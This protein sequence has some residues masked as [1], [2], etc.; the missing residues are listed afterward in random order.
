[1]NTASPKSTAS[2]ASDF[3][4]QKYRPHGLAQWVEYYWLV[5]TNPVFRAA[6]DKYKV[7]HEYRLG[8]HYSSPCA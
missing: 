2:P 1:M 7:Y 4:G 6:A 8:K 5:T 3:A